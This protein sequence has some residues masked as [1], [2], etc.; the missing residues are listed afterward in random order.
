MC[1]TQCCTLSL[2][3]AVHWVGGALF[4]SSWRWVKDLL[5]CD[6]SSGEE[7]EKS[8][9]GDGQILQEKECRWTSGA[10]DQLYQGREDERQ[11]GA[12]HRTHQ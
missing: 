1:Y 7:A 8:D 10:S 3:R 12:T 5:D 9:Q 6:V 11:G 4:S 2:Y